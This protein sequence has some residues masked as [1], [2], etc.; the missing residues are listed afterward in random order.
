MGSNYNFPSKFGSTS[1][2]SIGEKMVIMRDLKK[3]KKI[4]ILLFQ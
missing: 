1:K 3:K 4:Y 2:L